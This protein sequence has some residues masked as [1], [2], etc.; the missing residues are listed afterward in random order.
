LPTSLVAQWHRASGASVRL[1]VFSV[2][3]KGREA[4]GASHSSE[5]PYAF[6]ELGSA[7]P[8]V[9]YGAVDR[10]VSAEMQHYWANFAATGDPNGPGL[11][12]WPLFESRN[13][14]FLEFKGSG[15]ATGREFRQPYFQ[16]FRED[17]EAKLAP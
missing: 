9:E 6:G 10:R 3:P 15:T 17:F 16:L 1:Y 7:H 5:L 4:L 12:E 14:A 8:G 11:P 2:T 13:Q